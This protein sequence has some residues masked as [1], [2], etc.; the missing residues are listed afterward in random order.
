[1]KLLLLLL[2]GLSATLLLGAITHQAIAVWWP[3]T[4]RGGFVNAV[5]AVHAP[6]Y[7]AAVI[8][9]FVLTIAL[10]SVIYLPFRS[11]VRAQYLDASQPWATGLFEIKEH[12]AAMALALLPAYWALW[13]GSSDLASRRAVTTIL[14]L[15]AWW[16]FLVGH[17]VNNVRGL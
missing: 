13:R 14:L 5:R 4:G 12:A 16:N 2:H 10:G 8:V 17:V 15:A 6:R 1:V 7:T 11:M 9:L 3:A